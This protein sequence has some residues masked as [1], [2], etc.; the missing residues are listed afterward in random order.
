M[1]GRKVFNAD[2]A[3]ACLAAAAEAGVARVA[4]AREHGV[5]ARSLNAWRLALTR[6]ERRPASKPKVVEWIAAP[7]RHAPTFVVHAGRF[8]VEVDPDFDAGAL[9]RLLAVV[10]A[11]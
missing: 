6:H 9:K 3:R 7:S 5:D 2:D 4:W 1:P 10:A 11:C 8:A